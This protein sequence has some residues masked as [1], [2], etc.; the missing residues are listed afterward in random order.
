MDNAKRVIK[1]FAISLAAVLIVAIFAGITFGGLGIITAG[2]MVTDNS[3]MEVGCESEESCLAI[4]LAYSRL[5][6][7]V[8]DEF[9]AES[10]DEKVEI[11]KEDNQLIISEH[12]SSWNWFGKNDDKKI[13]VYVPKDMELERVEISGGVGDVNIESLKAKTMKM[14]FGVGAATIEFLEVENAEISSGIG[15]INVNLVSDAK[16][17]TVNLSKGLGEVRFNGTTVGNDAT[18]GNGERLVKISGGIGAINVN[19]AK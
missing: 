4:S 9:T 10:N 3:K 5:E 18:I 8:G 7:K 15:E 12:D 14:S 17:Y 16:D 1:Y 19:T 11:S 2:Q 6:I 13:T